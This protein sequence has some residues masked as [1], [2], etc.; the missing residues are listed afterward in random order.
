VKDAARLN[1]P[2]YGG[3]YSAGEGCIRKGKEAM[4]RLQ[5]IKENFIC[6]TPYGGN[7]EKK[8]RAD[9]EKARKI[10]KKVGERF[11]WWGSLP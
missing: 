10:W 6:R 5:A 9:L 3:A 2:S 7:R 8:I 11:R 4:S 1:L